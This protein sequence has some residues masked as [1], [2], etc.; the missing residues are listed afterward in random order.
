MITDH[1]LSS[2]IFLLWLRN[3][4][5]IGHGSIKRCILC[6]FPKM[7]LLLH[8]NTL[9]LPLRPTFPLLFVPQELKAVAPPPHTPPKRI[10]HIAQVWDQSNLCGTTEYTNLRS[11]ISLAKGMANCER[12]WE[13]QRIKHGAATAFDLSFPPFLF[14]KGPVRSRP[15]DAWAGAP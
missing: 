2:R 1:I 12:C 10:I 9:I 11:D 3:N 5:P 13:R 8:P 7:P 4:L 14:F 15:S 6:Y